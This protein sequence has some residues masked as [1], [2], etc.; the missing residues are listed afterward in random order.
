M[1]VSEKV[2]EL[3]R[4][5]SWIFKWNNILRNKKQSFRH[6]KEKEKMNGKN[7]EL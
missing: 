6:V 7:F 2:R 4:V 5:L 3:K 1:F